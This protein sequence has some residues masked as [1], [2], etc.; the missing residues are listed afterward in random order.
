MINIMED[1]NTFSKFT[2]QTQ[3]KVKNTKIQNTKYK[4][5]YHEY[6]EKYILPKCLTA[7]I[8]ILEK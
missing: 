2:L 4:A 1:K 7:K 6:V 3:A 5:F 8:Q